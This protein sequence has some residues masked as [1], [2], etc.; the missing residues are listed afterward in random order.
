M[1]SK[2]NGGQIRLLGCLYKY[3]PLYFAFQHLQTLLQRPFLFS[4]SLFLSLLAISSNTS[5]TPPH[6]QNSP[7]KPPEKKSGEH[8]KEP[9]E[10]SVGETASCFDGVSDRR[11]GGGG[12]WGGVLWWW[13]WR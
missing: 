8:P 2:V 13:G 11:W 12:G 10:T 6:R 9:F 1:N 3:P 4:I 7:S 5:S